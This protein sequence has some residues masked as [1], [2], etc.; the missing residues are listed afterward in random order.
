M[1]KFILVLNYCLLFLI[2]LLIFTL[3]S[4]NN[5]HYNKGYRL[6]KDG[7]IY[8]GNSQKLYTGIV[9]DTNSV[10]V[11]F[12]V[13]KGVK[14]GKFE[15]F[16]LDGKLEGSGHVVNNKSEGEWDYFYN[17]GQ[18]ACKGH[19]I[20]DLPDGRWETYYENGKLRSSGILYNGK[21]TGLWGFY[22]VKGNLINY[23]FYKN[24]FFFDKAF[25]GV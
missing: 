2:V 4:L 25:N 21:M 14:N 7:L 3:F 6:A 13:V 5:I 10:I 19:F 18:L 17:N 24:G 1:K 16:Y 20:N 15:T 22:D 9:I 23:A 12:D 11:T 8:A